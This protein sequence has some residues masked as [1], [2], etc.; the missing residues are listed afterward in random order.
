M[1]EKFG[2]VQA[3]PIS[4]S[5]VT[6]GYSYRENDQAGTIYA[7][8]LMPILK[9]NEEGLRQQHTDIYSVLRRFKVELFLRL[10]VYDW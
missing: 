5:A 6:V 9:R 8:R 10:I 2:K 1:D 4:H 7:D 3:G